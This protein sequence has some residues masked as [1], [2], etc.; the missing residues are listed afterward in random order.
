VSVILDASAVLAVILDEDG[1]NFVLPHVFGAHLA[2]VNL[3]ETIAKLIEYKL[4][5]EQAVQ[6]VGRLE[7][8][9]HDFDFDQAERAAVLKDRTKHFGLS[10]GDRACIA[11]SQKLELA[12]LTSDRRMAEAGATLGID[13]QQIR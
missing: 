3:S 1:S 5:C 6:Q 11:L 13:I 10:L 7:L 12:I 8:Q 9:I 2:A 4:T